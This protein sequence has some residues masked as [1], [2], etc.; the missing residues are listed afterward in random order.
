LGRHP[1]N[2]VRLRFL[3]I[4]STNDWSTYLSAQASASA[5]LTGLVFV[6]VSIN[7]TRVISVPGL[8]GRAAESIIQLFGVFIVSTTV[9]VPR[10]SAVALGVEILALASVFWLFQTLLQVIYMRR[11]TGHPLHWLISRVIQTY[12]GSIPF[13]VS[14]VLLIR[15]SS[16]GLYWLVPGF[17]FSLVSGVANAWVLLVEILR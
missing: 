8:V 10:Q 5:S 3:D 17:V 16:A 11:R 9:L 6:A 1:W 7:L 4:V 2:C 14:G 12:L 15:G 13:F